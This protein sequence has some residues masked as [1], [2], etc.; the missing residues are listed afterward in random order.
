M[1]ADGTV[2]GVP[3][4]RAS[5]SAVRAVGPSISLKERKITLLHQ[6]HVLNQGLLAVGLSRDRTGSHRYRGAPLISYC[7]KSCLSQAEPPLTLPAT[8]QQAIPASRSFSDRNREAASQGATASSG[9][10]PLTSQPP[11]LHV[12]VR[13][14]SVTVSGLGLESRNSLPT[15][16]VRTSEHAFNSVYPA[17]RR[18]RS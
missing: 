2:P 17:T 14:G 15:R 10:P 13:I 12:H 7:R 1:G 9:A 11:C 3:P 6:S 5:S 16:R 18:A 4:S 8:V